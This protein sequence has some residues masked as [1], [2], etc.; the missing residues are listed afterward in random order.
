MIRWY[1][2][3]I[4]IKKDNGFDYTYSNKPVLQQFVHD[5]WKD[6]PTYIEEVEIHA[7]G[8]ELRRS[9]SYSG[10]SY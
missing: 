8:N 2:Q 5:T 1:I 6:I 10:I 4:T 3:K 7:D 9:G